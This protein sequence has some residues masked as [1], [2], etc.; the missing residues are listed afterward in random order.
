MKIPAQREGSSSRCKP[1]GPW[2]G[3]AAPG[4]AAPLAGDLGFF[5]FESPEPGTSGLVVI[6]GPMIVRGGGDCRSRGGGVFLVTHRSR[7]ALHRAQSFCPWRF[8]AHRRCWVHFADEETEARGGRDLAPVLLPV[9]FH[10]RG[11]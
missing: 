1:Q 3:P 4:P 6:Q 8:D 11:Q 5:V 2:P 10:T 9:L 7:H